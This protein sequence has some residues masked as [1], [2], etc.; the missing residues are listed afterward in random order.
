MFGMGQK[1][2]VFKKMHCRLQVQ[3]LPDANPPT[4]KIQQFSKIYISF[5]PLMQN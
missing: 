2:S 4:G 5:D 1:A 3:T